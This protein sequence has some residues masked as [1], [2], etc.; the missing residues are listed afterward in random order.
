MELKIDELK[1]LLSKIS[2]AVEKSKI[3][4]KSGWVELLV[5]DTNLV[6]KVSNGDSYYLEASCTIAGSNIDSKFHVTVLAE[7]FI[8]LVSKLDDDTLTMKEY[9]NTL[10]IET[11]TSTYNVATIKELGK[12][13]SIDTIPFKASSDEVITIDSEN[14]VS[15]ASVNLKNYGGYRELNDKSAQFIYIDALGAITR[16]DECYALRSTSMPFRS[17]R[18]RRPWK[19]RPGWQRQQHAELP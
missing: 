14:L 15:V 17:R 3:N 1:D 7:T 9:L 16:V 18:S 13:R 4:P 5:Q 6:F 11:P 2:T 19:R 10:I 8:P 12:P